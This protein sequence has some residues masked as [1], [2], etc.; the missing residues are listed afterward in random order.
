MDLKTKEAMINAIKKIEPRKF[1]N[2]LSEL[3]KIGEITIKGD[4]IAGQ[5]IP[6]WIDLTI[7]QLLKKHV[8]KK[9]EVDKLINEFEKFGFQNIPTLD[10]KFSLMALMS[11]YSKGEKPSD[12]ID[13]MRIANGLPISDY[14]FTDRRRKAELVESGLPSKYNSKVFCGTQ[15]DL[16]EFLA[17]INNI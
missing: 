2:R 6:N 13:L 8:F 11:V 12:H 10:I 14:L 15:N 5:S 17:E 1:I 7:D 9:N 3:N 4:L 16:E